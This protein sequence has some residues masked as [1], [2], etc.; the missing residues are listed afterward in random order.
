MNQKTP[1]KD[2][3]AVLLDMDG[4]LWRE[5]QPIVDLVDVFSRIDQLGWPVICLTNNST[6]HPRQ[7]LALLKEFGVDLEEWQVISSSEAAAVYLQ[8][9]IPEES[10]VH[11]VGEHGLVE[12]VKMKGFRIHQGKRDD[13]E[14]AAVVVGLDRKLTYQKIARAADHIRSG[15]LFVG[16]N[17]D[18]TFPAR[19]GVMPG[20]GTVVVAVETAAEQDAV[21]IGKPEKPFFQTALERLACDP[22][23]VLMIGDRLETDILGAQKMGIQTAVVLSGIVSEEEAKQWQPAPNYIAEDIA[24][25]LDPWIS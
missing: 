9:K 2:V 8:E 25:L 20:A 3:Q 1:P 7:Y 15:A 17:P 6:K 12:A 11:V 4:V 10:R 22:Q 14:V 18:K 24:A 13:R 19:S 16:T 21:M 23:H 5:S